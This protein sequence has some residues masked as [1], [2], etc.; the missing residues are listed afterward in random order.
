[1]KRSG[2]I[3]FWL[4]PY[5]LCLSSFRTVTLCY[6]MKLLHLRERK[7]TRL[8]WM[9][10]QKIQSQ[11]HQ[12]RMVDQCLI[13]NIFNAI[14]ARARRWLQ[15]EHKTVNHKTKGSFLK[16]PR[17]SV[18]R[19]LEDELFFDPREDWMRVGTRKSETFRVSPSV[20]SLF[21]ENNNNNKIVSSF[22]FSTQIRGSWVIR[23]KQSVCFS[24]I[25]T[26]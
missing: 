5:L 16:S 13:E 3:F 4:T 23:T 9:K 1:M 6:M 25:R 11:L 26:L 15:Q 20:L 21:N 7:S 17:N 22:V 2:H 12:I 24:Y 14:Q 8:N 18:S 10:W 19:V